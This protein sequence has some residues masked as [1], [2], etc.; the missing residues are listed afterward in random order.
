MLTSQTR[1]LCVADTYF[2]LYAL[3]PSLSSGGA[4]LD[5]NSAVALGGAAD[6]IA[7]EDAH[8]RAPVRRVCRFRLSMMLQAAF[9]IA[10]GFSH[11]A[12]RRPCENAAYQ[13]PLDVLT[14][15]ANVE[16]GECVRHRSVLAT[17]SMRGTPP[18]VTPA[19]NLEAPNDSALD[20]SF[21]GQRVGIRVGG[22]AARMP[23]VASDETADAD[24]S[25]VRVCVA[26]GWV[27][28][29]L[30]LEYSNG[31]R[32][33]FF[34][35][36]DGSPVPL[37]DDAAMQRRSGVWHEVFPEEKLVAISGCNSRLRPTSYLCGMVALHLSSGRTIMCVGDNPFVWPA[38]LSTPFMHKA[39]GDGVHEPTFFIDGC[40]T[41][42]RLL[43][44]PQG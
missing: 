30:V 44:R 10:T 33:G 7:A 2:V 1:L 25:L 18:L 35:E 17:P 29:G 11:T 23:Q 42:L 19:F 40:C 36:N 3:E 27:V 41:G 5:P 28:H 13:E 12:L 16:H 4:S 6:R 22:R 39:P 32:T 31:M 38:V 37:S 21:M 26:S 43:S 9:L 14:V 15:L 20:I 34:L 24:P 8:T